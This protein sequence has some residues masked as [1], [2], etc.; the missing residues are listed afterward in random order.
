M[1]M[2]EDGTTTTSGGDELARGIAEGWIRPA[3]KTRSL[4]APKRFA[5]AEP[6]LEVLGSDR[7]N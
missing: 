5:S 7:G 6:I 3:T 4:R 2:D 1:Y